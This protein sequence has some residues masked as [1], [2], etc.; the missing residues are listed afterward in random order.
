MNEKYSGQPTNLLENEPP[1]LVRFL[2]R[3]KNEKRWEYDF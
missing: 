1:V 3:K 2:E